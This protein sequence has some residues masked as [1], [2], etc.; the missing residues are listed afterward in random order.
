MSDDVPKGFPWSPT[1]ML[2]LSRRRRSFLL[3]Q[4]SENAALRAEVAEWKRVGSLWWGPK[5]PE[6]FTPKHLEEVWEDEQAAQE[7]KDVEIESSRERVKT[8]HDIL[9]EAGIFKE[10]GTHPQIIG[11][12][13]MLVDE[14]ERLK[15]AD[16]DRNLFAAK[17]YAGLAEII[18]PPA[19]PGRG[20]E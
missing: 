7:A 5:L 10:N 9:D 20:E 8:L 3:E 15:K 4:A 17:L 1:E 16:A 13:R 11:R 14:V 12:V 19:E 6:P 2:A 18:G